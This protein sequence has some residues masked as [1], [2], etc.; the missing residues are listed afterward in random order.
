MLEDGRDGAI[1]NVQGKLVNEVDVPYLGYPGKE[2]VAEATRRNVP[3]IL[4]MKFFLVNQRLYEL[5]VVMY[6]DKEASKLLL[7]NFTI[8]LP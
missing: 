8:H 2:I 1:N 7:K 3:Y 4:K 6:K 5:S